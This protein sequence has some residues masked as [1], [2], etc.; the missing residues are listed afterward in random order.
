MEKTSTEHI[1]YAII[2]QAHT[3]MYLTPCSG[4]P[5]QRIEECTIEMEFL[6]ASVL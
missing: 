4:L 3:P 1:D 5:W 2:A 6:A